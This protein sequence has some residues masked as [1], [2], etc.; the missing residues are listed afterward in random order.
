MRFFGHVVQDEKGMYRGY[1]PML[2]PID[3]RTKL[4]DHFGWAISRA[5]FDAEIAARDADEPIQVVRD[6]E[7][8]RA[9]IV[10]GRA[11]ELAQSSLDDM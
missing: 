2:V 11:S 6:Q 4:L 7:H 3:H 1:W 9:L 10:A 5:E 8:Y